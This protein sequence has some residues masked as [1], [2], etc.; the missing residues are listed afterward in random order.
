MIE[1]SEEYFQN[2]FIWKRLDG[3]MQLKFFINNIL[4]KETIS[5]KNNACS[6]VSIEK[7]LGE[8]KHWNKPSGGNSGIA[9]WDIVCV[10]RLGKS[11]KRAEKG[12][13]GKTEDVVWKVGKGSIGQQLPKCS[14]SFFFTDSGNIGKN[15]F[16][17]F[18]ES[19]RKI[20]KESLKATSIKTSKMCNTNKTNSNNVIKCHFFDWYKFYLNIYTAHTFG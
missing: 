15:D 4:R 1:K 7:W 11:I 18:G 6:K 10:K 19:S 8:L 3:S 13:K 17:R 12:D 20:R 2:E 5:K 16:C 14:Q 9:L